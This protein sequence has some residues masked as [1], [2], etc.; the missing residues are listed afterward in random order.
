M[1]HHP[2]A[3]VGDPWHETRIKFFGQMSMKYLTNDMIKKV[4]ASLRAK[5]GDE[6]VDG[7]DI[8]SSHWEAN[9]DLHGIQSLVSMTNYVPGQ[10]VPMFRKS[11]SGGNA[12]NAEQVAARVV[13]LNVDSSGSFVTDIASRLGDPVDQQRF[14]H[15]LSNA[16]ASKAD[17]KSN[18]NLYKAMTKKAPTGAEEVRN[19]L[20]QSPFWDADLDASTVSTGDG[21]EATG[22]FWH[23]KYAND[24]EWRAGDPSTNYATASPVAYTPGESTWENTPWAIAARASGA[25][26]T[27]RDVSRPSRGSDFGRMDSHMDDILG[28]GASA[29]FARIGTKESS[30]PEKDGTPWNDIDLNNGLDGFGGSCRDGD[31][32]AYLFDALSKNP[33][34][35]LRDRFNF[36][37]HDGWAQWFLMLVA[38]NDNLIKLVEK[39]VWIPFN[40]VLF[41][42]NMTY[43]MC[44][45]IMMKGGMETGMTAVGHN[46]FQLGD[47]VAAKMHYGHYTF[48]SKAF[49]QQPRNIIIAENIFA[50]GYKHGTNGCNWVEKSYLYNHDENDTGCLH[51]WIVP[52]GETSTVY[53]NPISMT[54]SFGTSQ[55]AAIEGAGHFHDAWAM[56]P[57][58][59]R[60]ADAFETPD[61]PE[62]LE[63]L[64]TLNVVCY[65]GHQFSYNRKTFAH[66]RVTRNTGHWGP[67]VYPGCAAVRAGEAQHFRDM[68]WKTNPM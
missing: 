41:R 57:D 24:P 21:W 18:K 27:Q 2:D 12:L 5:F 60:R 39:D 22:E 13:S 25:S 46:D 4:A 26:T 17:L 52:Y 16:L 51:A 66:D 43:D 8:Q 65:Q 56:K 11:S 20:I 44:S 38:T 29:K 47:D 6:K 32:I 67:N 58:V 31:R 42:P 19:W 48:K 33:N 63:N 14:L 3:K 23:P 1:Y 68:G 45:A 53:P 49:V 37:K 64:N 9:G 34:T 50:Q 61:S 30:H 54:G 35:T 62:F 15:G 59:A 7:G 40:V 28:I 55:K 10:K 36:F